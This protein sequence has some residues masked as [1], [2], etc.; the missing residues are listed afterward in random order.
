MK[1]N[2]REY[3]GKMIRILFIYLSIDSYKHHTLAELFGN[4]SSN[5]KKV[6]KSNKTKKKN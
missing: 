6:G 1:A 5:E 4:A 2:S 3:P